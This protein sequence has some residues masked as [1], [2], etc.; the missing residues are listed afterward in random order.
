MTS[1]AGKYTDTHSDKSEPDV[2]QGDPT[3]VWIPNAAFQPQRNVEEIQ[4]GARRL[5]VQGHWQA[6]F[7][8]TLMKFPTQ[9]GRLLRLGER[10]H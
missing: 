2:G 4:Q 7:T 1:Q 5:Q 10:A 6:G 8:L 9:A 3:A